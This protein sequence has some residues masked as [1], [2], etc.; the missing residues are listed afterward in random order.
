M[1]ESTEGVYMSEQT[2]ALFSALMDGELTEL[3]FR[4]LLK[5]LKSDDSASQAWESYNRA[6]AVMHRLPGATAKTPDIS[7][8]VM[9]S[10]AAIGPL[11]QNT[12]QPIDFKAAPVAANDDGKMS[13]MWKSLTSM[14]VAATVTAVVVLGSQYTAVINGEA[15]SHVD[16]RV[17]VDI[18]AF[19]TPE[20]FQRTQLS[21]AEP[22]PVV[23]AATDL[24]T[25]EQLERGV[26]RYLTQHQF[27]QSN[28]KPHWDVA[29]LPEGIRRV[30]EHVF[31]SGSEVV[32][33]A[34]DNVSF[35]VSVEP[36]G[37]QGLPTGRIQGNGLVAVGKPVGE[38]FIA[39]VGNLEMADA[40]RVLS[41]VVPLRDE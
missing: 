32:S 2:K 24:S 27:V 1:K 26:A 31:A 25:Q 30:N 6:R 11:E 13:A 18:P 5:E 23:S 17:Q 7:A 8:S 10:I 34:S 3:E 41:S 22:E 16:T 40:E 28:L 19:S 14:A 33:F 9:E 39:V 35:S 36:L 38:V 4:R 21:V 20:N 15:P 12:D 29:W 37:R